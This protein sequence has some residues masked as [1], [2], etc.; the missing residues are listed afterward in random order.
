[1][2]DLK[3]FS[4]PFT[5]LS[6]GKHQFDFHVGDE[7]FG[8]FGPLEYRNFDIQV[9]MEMN[10]SERML[11]LAFTFKGSVELRC[12]LTDEP[13]NHPFDEHFD[14]IVKF[15]PEFNNDD[16][17]VLVLPYE[18]VEVDVAPFIRDIIS[19]AIPM[20]KVHP[21]VENG[22]FE[23]EMLDRLDELSP[24]IKEEKEEGEATDPRWDKL[25]DLLND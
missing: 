19:L 24:E 5:G 20:K 8:F 18:A 4:I 22:T 10:K 9:D 3:E 2:K 7:F 25:K 1:M 15:G 12:D 23:S 6:L 17:E 14:W 16:E 13:F 11:E 21:G